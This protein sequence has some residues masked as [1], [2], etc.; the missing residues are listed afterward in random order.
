MAT[1]GLA[2][3]RPTTRV[4]SQE[5]TDRAHRSPDVASKAGVE[6]AKAQLASAEAGRR[7]R[8]RRTSAPAGTWRTK[9]FASRQALETAQANRDQA[10]AAVAGAQA[11]LAAS[12]ANVDVTQ[13]QEHEAQRAL[14]ELRTAAGQGGARSCVHRNPCADRRRDRQSRRA[15]RRLCADRSAA[16]QP[17][18]ARRRLYR[19]QLQGDAARAPAPGAEGRDQR[20]RTAGACASR[21][22]CD[23][24]APAS[25]AVFSLLPPDNAT[26]NFTKI[27]QRVPVRVRV[28]AEVADA[29]AAA[30]RHVGGR[31]RQHQADNCRR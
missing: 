25:G 15:D 18:A 27:V 24:F 12:Q 30:A 22:P 8:R 5:A 19:R 21:G 23:S 9:D 10:R 6:Q 7:S 1:T 3:D 11:A 16:R 26:G 4:A 28:P 14:A 29:R 31:E 13:A 17:G 20:R 2:A